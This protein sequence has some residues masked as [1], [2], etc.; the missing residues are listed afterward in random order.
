VKTSVDRIL[1]T[2]VGS[3]V[4]TP[5]IIELQVKKSLG[6]PV[7]EAQFNVAIRDGVREVVQRQ[8]EVGVDII[9]DGEYGKLNW[10]TY[11]G[12]RLSGLKKT[13]F[14][15][16]PEEGAK[17]WP[18]QQ[19]F[20]EFYKA[21]MCHESTDWLPDTPALARYTDINMTDY[22]NVVCD[23]ELAYRPAALQR[24]I[25]NLQ[26][27]LAGKKH[28]EAFMPVVAPGSIEVVPNQFYAS[29][30]DYLFA[31][32]R[33]L[34]KEYRQIVD[35]GFI[36]QV[37]DAIVPAAYYYQFLDQPLS[38]YLAWAELRIEALNRALSGIAQERVRYHICFGSQNMPHT[39]DPN[40]KDI[41][42][43]LLKVNAQAFSIEA[44]NPRHA[45]EWQ[46]WRNIKLPAGKVLIPG[47]VSHSTNVVEHPELIAER[48][49]NFAS[50][51]GRENVIAGTDCGFSQGWN[52]PRVHW[53]VQWAKL[54]TLVAGARL[55]SERLWGRRGD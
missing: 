23:A 48:I 42:P 18:E 52:S 49:G 29:Q 20:G 37:D 25:R 16:S 5:A 36:L 9:D 35:A 11:L 2:H 28:V 4:R 21:Y 24:D 17:F 50:L 53:Q 40:L 26:D 47:M 1:T 54:E 6:E 10:I 43:L 14:H 27:A 19:R 55:A 51:V 38:A 33:E 39:T 8:I 41:M 7:D 34:N 3:L 13:D 31:L 22:Q 45:H 30:Q 12:D 15:A 32:A 46:I 44:G